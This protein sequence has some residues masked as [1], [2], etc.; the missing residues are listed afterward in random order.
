MIAFLQSDIGIAITIY[1]IIC[2]GMLGSLSLGAKL[3]KKK[4]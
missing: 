3:E 4:K 2:V 1:G